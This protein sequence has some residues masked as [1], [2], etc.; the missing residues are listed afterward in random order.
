MSGSAPAGIRMHFVLAFTLAS[1]MV[2][3]A[4][5]C[6]GP[7]PINYYT[8]VVPTAPANDRTAKPYPVTLQV[9]RMA[10]PPMM[11]SGGILYETGTNQ[12]GV[13]SS[14]HWAEPPDLMVQSWLIRLLNSS[15]KYE[16]VSERNSNAISDYVLRGKLYDFAEIDGSGI[17][18]R[19][20]MELELYQ[21]KS[22][23]TV[24]TEFYTHDEPVNGREVANV[25]QSLE[26]NLS[27]GLREVADG[28]DRYFSQQRTARTDGSQQ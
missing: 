12:I 11:R 21:V 19:V 22:G 13:Y 4:A 6:A 28:L 2:M 17:Q 3:L 24:W 27:Q 5:G 25:V 7:R 20:S 26:N 18:T 15:G 10:C 14:H 1:I 8:I 23:R 16:S 9:A